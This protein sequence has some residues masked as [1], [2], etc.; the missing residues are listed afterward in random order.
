MRSTHQSPQPKQSRE[1]S[2]GCQGSPAPSV[3]RPL[4]AEERLLQGRGPA[5]WAEPVK[6]FAPVSCF[7]T[8]SASS[9]TSGPIII[10]KAV[11]S[12]QFCNPGPSPISS[13]PAF[14]PQKPGSRCRPGWRSGD[15]E[16]GAVLFC[17]FLNSAELLGPV[18]V[19]R[20]WRGERRVH[21]ENLAPCQNPNLMCCTDGLPVKR[22]GPSTPFSLQVLCCVMQSTSEPLQNHETRSLKVVPSTTR[23]PEHNASAHLFE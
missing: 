1:G 12:F 5:Q 14:L 8:V 17:F 15:G 13:P 18:G 2:S 6:C 11:S 22:G 3:S 21:P 7:P 10:P 9:H 16:I 4:G 23:P 19:Q 20:E